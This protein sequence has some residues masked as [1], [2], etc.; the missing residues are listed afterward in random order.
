MFGYAPTV[1]DRSGEITAAGQLQGSQ[2]I[3]AGIGTAASGISSAINDITKLNLAGQQAQGTLGIAH[4]LGLI[5]DTYKGLPMIQQI[6]AAQNISPMINALAS[7][8][9]ATALADYRAQTLGLKQQKDDGST[10]GKGI[11]SF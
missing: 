3:A 2:G 10:A 8:N 7:R 11:T 1:N 6:G 5:D 9:Q 4:S